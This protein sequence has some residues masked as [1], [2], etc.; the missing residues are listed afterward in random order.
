MCLLGIE[1]MT[2][3]LPVTGT[4]Q[5]SNVNWSLSPELFVKYRSFLLNFTHELIL[6][7]LLISYL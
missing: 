5:H 4:L 2:F 6:V 1:P 7:K 3:M